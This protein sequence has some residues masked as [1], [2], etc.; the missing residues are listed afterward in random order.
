MR[1]LG[2]SDLTANFD[3]NLVIVLKNLSKST[4]IYHAATLVKWLL[5][6][7]VD[8]DFQLVAGQLNFISS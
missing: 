7:I 6:S 4:K 1:I 8:S 3:A 2:K 5:L